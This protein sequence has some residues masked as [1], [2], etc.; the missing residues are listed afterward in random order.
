MAD[1][2]LLKG[3]TVITVDPN[4]GDIAGGDV[5]IEGDTIAEVARTSPPTPRSSTP[6]ATS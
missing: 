6:R 1:R 3:G 2:I 4:L 5:L